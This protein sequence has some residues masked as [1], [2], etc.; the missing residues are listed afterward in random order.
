MAEDKVTLE[1]VTPQGLALRE[2][3]DEVTAPSV[4]GEFGVL[5]GH[6]PL[7]AALRTGIVTFHKGGAETRLA[8]G[9]GFVEVKDDRALL[10]T[11]KV[12]HKEQLDPV[13]LRLELKEVD[14]QLDHY[15]GP[16]GGPEWQALVRRELWA[17]TQLELYGDPAPATQRP[18]ELFGPPG[19]PPETETALPEP[20][21]ELEAT[22]EGH[23]S[24][25]GTRAKPS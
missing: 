14:E 12:A 24:T 25:T 16:P 4:T 15:A 23:L 8:V 21:T 7:L 2:Q 13:R 6:L 9:E 18:F 11:D 10:L 17:A 22:V 20:E 5:P 3:V 19:P 1:I